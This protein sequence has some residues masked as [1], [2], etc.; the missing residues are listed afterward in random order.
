MEAPPHTH[1]IYSKL[2]TPQELLEAFHA[3]LALGN[4]K[5]NWR[6]F[7]DLTDMEGGHSVL[8]LYGLIDLFEAKNMPRTMREAIL[9]PTL[10]STHEEVRFYETTCVNRGFFIR[11]FTRREDALAWLTGSGG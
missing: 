9:M 1:L 10:S 3:A 8:D 4:E 2:V 11:V 5:R 7:A 6:Y